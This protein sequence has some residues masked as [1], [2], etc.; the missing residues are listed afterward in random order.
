[1]AHGVTPVLI[2]PM[3]RRTFDSQG[4]ITNSHG[5]YPEAVRQVARE[6]NV[7]LIDLH[8]MSTRFYEALGPEKSKLA[9]KDGDGTHH[10]NYGSYELAKCV[11]EGIRSA[12]LPI[13]KSLVK[14][15]PTFDPSH[16]D[17]LESFS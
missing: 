1:R 16:P 12:K 6:D 9:F 13:V 2:T 11:V 3:Q 10:N 15:M 4:K 7:A 14:G 8:E 5:D 17:Q